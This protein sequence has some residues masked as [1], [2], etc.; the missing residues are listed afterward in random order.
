MGASI[1]VFIKKVQ[2][3]DNT[4]LIGLTMDI[5]L[6]FVFHKILLPLVSMI[7]ANFVNCKCL[8]GLWLKKHT[9]IAKELQCETL[10]KGLRGFV[11]PNLSHEPYNAH[12]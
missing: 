10:K 4:C 2:Y 11:L 6:V 7:C 9:K 12:P 1:I 8:L 3:S 5:H